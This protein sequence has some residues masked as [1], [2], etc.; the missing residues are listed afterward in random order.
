MSRDYH[1]EV[2]QQIRRSLPE[3]A[4][5]NRIKLSEQVMDNLAMWV[6][7]AAPRGLAKV[8]CTGRL[9]QPSDGSWACACTGACS[10]W[11]RVTQEAPDD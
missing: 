8:T 7:S 10:K 11:V 3:F 6:A 9:P 5:R 1:D 4:E 2:V